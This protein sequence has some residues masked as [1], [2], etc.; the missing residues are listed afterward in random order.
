MKRELL[1]TI[2]GLFVALL[3]FTACSDDDESDM[4]SFFGKEIPYVAMPADAPQWVLEKLDLPE[5]KIP[6]MICQGVLDGETIYYFYCSFMSNFGEV[7]D[8]DGNTIQ[9]V[10]RDVIGEQWVC[11]HYIEGF[12]TPK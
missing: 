1:K 4:V 11:I 10:S 12:P 2:L 3:T 5:Y 8:K 9:S 6:C 7:C